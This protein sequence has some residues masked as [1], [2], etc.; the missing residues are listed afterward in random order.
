MLSLR[1]QCLQ[2]NRVNFANFSPIPLNTV[3]TH[4][5]T[6]KYQSPVCFDSHSLSFFSQYWDG[7]WFIHFCCYFPN[8]RGSFRSVGRDNIA[9][10]LGTSPLL[11]TLCWYLTFWYSLS[12][13]LT[14]L[15]LTPFCLSLSWSNEAVAIYWVQLFL[16]R[17]K[18]QTIKY[19]TP[20]W[21]KCRNA[22]S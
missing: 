6:R 9:A 1:K 10:K 5:L 14:S 4:T 8:S 15:I 21:I 13:W 12:G 3:S 22:D 7:K 11:L 16:L 17:M 20:C 18:Q 2:S 19:W